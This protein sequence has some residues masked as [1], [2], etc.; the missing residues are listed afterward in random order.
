MQ[1]CMRP[2]YSA[3]ATTNPPRE[4]RSTS[5]DAIRHAS[6]LVMNASK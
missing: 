6:P 4:M 3:A 1:V 2:D 5:S